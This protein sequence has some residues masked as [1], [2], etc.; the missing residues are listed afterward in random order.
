MSANSEGHIKVDS[1]DVVREGEL[2]ALY[3]SVSCG[4]QTESSYTLIHKCICISI[5]DLSS[6]SAKKYTSM[7]C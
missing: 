2:S 1:K 7:A 4:S 3:V 6:S 5:L